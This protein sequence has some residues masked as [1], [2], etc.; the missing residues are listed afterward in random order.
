MKLKSILLFIGIILSFSTWN[1]SFANWY[2]EHSINYS[3]WSTTRCTWDGDCT[4]NSDWTISSCTGNDYPNIDFNKEKSWNQYK[5]YAVDINWDN[6]ITSADYVSSSTN[7]KVKNVNPSWTMNCF[8]W[9]GIKPTL[10]NLTLSLSW[11][12]PSHNVLASNSATLSISYNDHNGW[13]NSTY[14]KITIYYQLENYNSCSNWFNSEQN[15]T[16][17]TKNSTASKDITWNISKVSPDCDFS[18]WIWWRQYS[19][20]IIKICD[21]ANNCI[22]PNKI[23]N[24]NVYANTPISYEA[25]K[26]NDFSNSYIA[27]NSE[28]FSWWI[29]LKDQ[30]WNPVLPS[31]GIDRKIS[32]WINYKNN[33]YLNQ[34]TSSWQS[35]IKIK[36]KWVNYST[37]IIWNSKFTTW[38]LSNLLNKSWYYWINIKSYVPTYIWYDKAYWNFN[39]KSLDYRITDSLWTDWTNSFGVSKKLKFKPQIYLTFKE[40]HILAW[41][42]TKKKFT[43]QTH[44]NENNYKSYTLWVKFSSANSKIKTYLSYESDSDWKNKSLYT[45]TWNDLSNNFWDINNNVAIL[46]FANINNKYIYEKF[47]LQTGWTLDPQT[48]KN[49]LSTHI[50]LKYTDGTIAI[51]NS[52]LVWADNYNYDT[53]NTQLSINPITIVWLIWWANFKNKVYNMFSWDKL[54][55]SATIYRPMIRSKIK[56]LVS[57]EL[58]GIKKKYSLWTKDIFGNGLITPNATINWAKIY[59]YKWVWANKNLIIPWDVG[60]NGKYLIVV[61]NANVFLTGNIQTTNKWIIW[62]IVLS[63]PNSPNGNIYVNNKVTNIDMFIYTDKALITYKWNPNWDFKTQEALTQD[64]LKNQL[65]IK[66]VLWSFNTIWWSVNRFCPFFNKNCANPKKYDLFNIRKFMLVKAS[67][68]DASGSNID[69]VPYGITQN[70]NNVSN[71]ILI[72]W[73]KCSLEDCNG[74]GYK[75]ADCKDKN[76]ELENKLN[77]TA[78]WCGKFTKSYIERNRRLFAPLYIEYDSR[79]HNM[80]LPIFSKM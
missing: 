58:G 24:W 21:E 3:N 33:V 35:W 48:D 60:I 18:W 66:W 53:V 28:Y 45:Y 63:K 6:K 75:E 26:L 39:L 1:F 78:L 17:D 37:G 38:T 67:D 50:I 74:D 11:K 2:G 47:L 22:T 62:L 56:Y 34:Y 43:F 14:S 70:I 7:Q 51:Y 80:N 27:D 36:F 46:P 61:E 16:L 19:V 8:Y 31:H 13:S 9:D 15:F 79:I 73:I 55:S 44:T 4:Y 54:Y 42:W 65:L 64:D 10:S 30:Y 76:N 77:N 69:Y 59:Y 72:W 52:D 32:I 20:K 25:T 71:T 23:Y 57:Q 5:D 41:E 68:I 12:F 40:S 49:V 29:L